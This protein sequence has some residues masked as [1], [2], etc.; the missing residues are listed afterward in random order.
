VAI[1]RDLAAV[2]DEEKRL[3]ALLAA[4]IA[5]GAVPLPQEVHTA[6]T[7]KPRPSID[8][9]RGGAY[10]VSPSA[11]IGGEPALFETGRAYWS[12]FLAQLER[13]EAASTSAAAEA[14]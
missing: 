7:S 6:V 5:L 11:S 10:L 1:T 8:W 3:V 2:R 9:M 12:E 13:A 14:A 4:L